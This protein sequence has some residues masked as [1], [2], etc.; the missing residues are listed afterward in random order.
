MRQLSGDAADEGREAARLGYQEVRYFAD[1]SI[2]ESSKAAERM[3]AV[4]WMEANGFDAKKSEASLRKFQR[5]SVI[6]AE[7]YDP[8]F[9]DHKP[10]KVATDSTASLFGAFKTAGT[11]EAWLAPRKK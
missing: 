5:D 3:E 9:P 2:E 11:G 7:G 10:R 6:R 8:D 1:L 4:V